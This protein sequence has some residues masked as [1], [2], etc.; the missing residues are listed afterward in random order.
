M[1]EERDPPN[2]ISIIYLGQSEVDDV[3]KLDL[4]QPI[5]CYL[6]GSL[7]VRD[8]IVPFLCY[9]WLLHSS[10]RNSSSH[11]RYKKYEAHTL[12]TVLKISYLK[13]L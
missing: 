1:G 8:A 10:L 9:C 2:M 6:F 4:Y 11:C 7:H 3:F 12:L 13:V 5:Q